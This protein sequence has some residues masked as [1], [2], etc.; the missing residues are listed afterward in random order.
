MYVN[1]YVCVYVS[2]HSSC[3]PRLRRLCQQVLPHL[4]VH[5]KI[6]VIVRF[7]SS[8]LMAGGAN[9]ELSRDVGESHERAH[10]FEVLLEGQ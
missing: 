3:P 4:L 2:R 9:L 8:T 7:C 5:L 6:Y 1:L 10:I